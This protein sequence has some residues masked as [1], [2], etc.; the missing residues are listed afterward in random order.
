MDRGGLLQEVPDLIGPDHLLL[1]INLF[2]DIPILRFE[3]LTGFRARD[4]A[5]SH[6]CPVDSHD[7]ISGK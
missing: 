5:L 1:G 2:Y 3:C 6:V 4:S 7:F